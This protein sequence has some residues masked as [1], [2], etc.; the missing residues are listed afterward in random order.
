MEIFNETDTS[1]EL[2][3]NIFISRACLTVGP[4]FVSCVVEVSLLELEPLCHTH[5]R[6]SVI[7]KTLT[8]TG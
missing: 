1:V 6:L 2:F 4:T 8:L 3:F 7:V 5:L